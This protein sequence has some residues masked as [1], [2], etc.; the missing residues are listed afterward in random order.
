MKS[1][2]GQR[3]VRCLGHYNLK[4]IEGG[5]RLISSGQLWLDYNADP[6]AES[7]LTLNAYYSLNDYLSTATDF[8]IYVPS[9]NDKVIQMIR[10]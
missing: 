1:V 3:E 5:Y 7:T 6:N 8:S 9:F 2:Y 10:S 4:S